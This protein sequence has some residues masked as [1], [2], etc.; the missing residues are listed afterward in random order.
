M[1]NETTV[2]EVSEESLA[3]AFLAV[4]AAANKKAENIKI[5]DL[6]KLSSF[7]DY[8]VVCSGQSDRQVQAIAD[9]IVIELKEDG[10]TPISMEGYREGRWVLVDYGDVVIHVFLDALREY[11]DIEQLW[12]NAP[13]V[14]I[15][16]ELYI[17]PPSH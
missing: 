6:K 5:L 11:Y 16:I 13:K 2:I 7:T 4:Q 12:Q 15:P 17:T 8:F 3:K 9:S 1:A 14:P 10:F